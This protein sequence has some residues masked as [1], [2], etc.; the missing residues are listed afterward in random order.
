MSLI[1]RALEASG[2]L[3]GARKSS[4]QMSE[5]AHHVPV[6][7]P[8]KLL[9]FIKHDLVPTLFDTVPRDVEENLRPI[10]PDV[11]IE[12][13]KQFVSDA[14]QPA[15][16][17]VKERSGMESSVAQGCLHVKVVILSG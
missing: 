10:Q 15:L 6:V 7:D 12:T 11:Q 5:T 13:C 4:S 14:A 3:V 17:V 9:I 2:G 8:E 1:G 16:Y